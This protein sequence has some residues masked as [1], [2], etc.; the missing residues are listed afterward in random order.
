MTPRQHNTGAT[1]DQGSFRDRSSRVYVVDGEI[2]RALDRA[3]KG[4]L[5][6][7]LA[8]PF[9]QRAVAA[10]QVVGTEWVEEGPASP[11]PPGPWVASVRHERIPLVSY[12]YEWSFGMLRDAARLQLELLNA[13]LAQGFILKDASAFNIQWRSGKPVF[14]DVGSFVRYQSGSPWPGYRQFCQ[15]FL[16]PLMLQ[17]YKGT[18]FHPWLRGRV[19]GIPPE[20]FASLLCLRDLFRPGVFVHAWLHAKASRGPGMA[21]AAGPHFT[22]D[23]IRT[24]VQALLRLVDRM[25]WSPARSIW[26]DY[27]ASNSYG[28]EDRAAKESFVASILGARRRRQVW[29][30]GSNTGTFARLAARDADLVLAIDADHLSVERLYRG[31]RAT[32]AANILPLVIQLADPSPG[33][34]WRGKERRTL[35]DRGRP[36]LVLALALLHH[37]VL[38]SN[39]PLDLVVEWLWSLGSEVVVEW[40]EREDPMAALL[41]AGRPDAV[42]YQRDHFE[43]LLSRRFATHAR[44][45]LPSGTRVLYHLG[46]SRP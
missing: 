10:G 28:S 33:L 35:E 32:P 2:F 12:P 8:A 9:F 39:V 36:D 19:D 7:A 24:N 31:L 30:L 26:S 17:A 5:E 42:D 13:A 1:Y 15:L 27:A 23:M 40:V 20:D 3:A 18:P 11:A 29:D 45:V 16:Y 34:G 43:Q 6:A 38:S 21:G 25:D 41:L 22:P 14:I 37:L 4:E 46:P 44:V